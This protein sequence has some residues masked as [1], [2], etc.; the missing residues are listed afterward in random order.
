MIP[1]EAGEGQPEACRGREQ[2][3]KAQSSPGGGR[4]A[5]SPVNAGKKQQA[6]CSKLIPI[7][8]F[9]RRYLSRITGLWG[10]MLINFNFFVSELWLVDLPKGFQKGK[11]RR[12]GTPNFGEIWTKVQNSTFSEREKLGVWKLVFFLQDPKLTHPQFSKFS[13]NYK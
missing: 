3:R 9:T 8:S 6:Y 5:I 10:V 12:L 2:R 1:A 11:D 4:S 7:Y 13:K